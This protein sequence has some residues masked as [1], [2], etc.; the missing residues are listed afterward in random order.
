MKSIKRMASDARYLLLMIKDIS[1]FVP[2]SFYKILV[3]I[4]VLS[5]LVKYLKDKRNKSH[6]K[7]QGNLIKQTKEISSQTFK[8]L[9]HLGPEFE[10]KES[11]GPTGPGDVNDE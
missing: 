8:D 5:F 4:V 3:A 7:Q 6:K 11:C 9:D 10:V 1:T 2:S